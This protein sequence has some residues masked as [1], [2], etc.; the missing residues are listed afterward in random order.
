MIGL[1]EIRETISQSLRKPKTTA[2]FC[3]PRPLLSQPSR[4]SASCTKI[5]S[6]HPNQGTNEV[7][8]A[9]VEER[10][11]REPSAR[12]RLSLHDYPHFMAFPAARYAKFHGEWQ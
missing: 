6:F 7:L 8:G 10:F 9:R 2:Q 12:S 4:S 11:L 3:N 5:L 1:D